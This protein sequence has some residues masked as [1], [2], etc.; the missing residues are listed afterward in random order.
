M[1]GAR[2]ALQLCHV[3]IVMSIEMNAVHTLAMAAIC[4]RA[5]KTVRKRKALMPV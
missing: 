2:R 1:R 4:H 3:K 5:R